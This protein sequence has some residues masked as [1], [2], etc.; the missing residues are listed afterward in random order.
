MKKSQL[1]EI[2]GRLTL[3]EKVGQL[4][5][6]GPMFFSKTGEITGPMQAMDM[7]QTELYQIGSILGTHTKEEVLHI[8]ET[9]LAE[10]THGIP[11]MFMAD[12]IHGYETIFPIPLALASSFDPALVRQMASLSAEEATAAGINVTFSPMAD[13]VRD[14]RWGRVLESNGEDPLLSSLLTKAY[15]EGY[16]GDSL[17][18]PKTLAACVKHFIGYGLA[19]GGRDYNT[20]D[21]SDLMLYQN[22]LPAFKAAIEAGVKLVM[23]SFNTVRGVPASGNKWLLQDVL[24]RDLGFDGLII[25]DWASIHELINHRVV[26][27]K[28]EATYKAATAGVEIDMMTDNY[29]HHL[30]ALV[31]EGLVSQDFI[32]TAV[33]HV[34]ELKNELGLFEDPY[35]SLQNRPL[36]S[37]SDLQAR[38]RQA[39]RDIASQSMVLLEN[40]DH[41]LPLKTTE[42]LAL[43][44][45]LA[46]SQDLLG[47]WSWIGKTEDVVTI[48]SGLQAQSEQLEV[49]KERHDFVKLKQ[50]DKVIVA[51][52]EHSLETGEGASKTD[53]RLPQA[54]LDLLKEVYKWNPNIV[55]VLIN[56][57][58]LDLIE[59]TPYCHSILEAWFPGSE[60]GHAIADVLFGRVNPAGKLPMSFP[61]SV[62]QVPISYNM[63]STGRQ[64]N[65]HNET[66]KYVS[67]YLDNENTPLYPFGYGL[68]Y[69]DIRL[70]DV[71]LDDQGDR[72]SVHY[73][74]SN[75]SQEAGQEVVQLYIKDLF[76]EVA[77]PEREL[78]A[79]EK[80]S[81]QAGESKDLSLTISA[82]DIAYYHSDLSF[83]AD[84]GTIEIYFGLDSQAAKVGVWDF[85]GE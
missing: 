28:R 3:E 46:D 19:E 67:K 4:V 18:D 78:K 42:K 71:R 26:A 29:Q 54:Q 45:P 81:L 11:L 73:R 16:Q 68:N 72:L 36:A 49:I 69:S 59:V 66:Q 8:Q 79:F 9:Y 15:V 74:L 7:T 17:L 41:L 76:T 35:R 52:G 80:I 53:I 5:Q 33:L 57:R 22:H 55:V 30:V 70:S 13:L 39:S 10:A 77:R 21:L 58:P 63:L 48:E 38:L 64:I 34:L 1:T 61:R 24:R 62:G 14:A 85:Q 31:K 56:G 20:V 44:G 25:S 75:H 2:L 47:A 65:E 40:K 23:T 12:V 27:D 60:A 43:L 32:D 84:P 82:Q 51:L 6:L 83:Q 50:V 37:S